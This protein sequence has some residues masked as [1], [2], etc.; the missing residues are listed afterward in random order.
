V[1]TVAPTGEGNEKIAWVLLPFSCLLLREKRLG[2]EGSTEYIVKSTWLNHQ[3]Q[4][5][6]EFLM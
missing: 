1:Y 3:F 4:S 6:G 5:I 2:D